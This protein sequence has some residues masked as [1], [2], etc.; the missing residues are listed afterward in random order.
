MRKFLGITTCL[1]ATLCLSGIG[2][3]ADTSPILIGHVNTYSGHG[4]F[5]G[6][7]AG[8]GARLAV[9]EIN[10]AGG[11]LGRKLK[12]IERD[13]QFKPDIGLKEAKDLILN[14]HVHFLTGTLS[15]SVALAVS[16]YA[17]EKKVMFISTLCQSAAITEEQGHRYV[18]RFGSNSTTIAA[19]P[20]M[21]AAKTWGGKKIF[22]LCPD[23]E[24]GHRAQKDFLEFYKK[25]VPD[26]QIV[27]ELWPKTGTTDFTPYISTIMASGADLVLIALVGGEEH[28]FVKQAYPYGFYDKMHVVELLAGSQENWSKV[29]KGQPAP[30]GSMTGCRYP[31][32]AIDDPRSQNFS[33]KFQEITGYVPQFTGITAYCMI[34]ALKESI[35]AAGGTDT[36]KNVDYWTGRVFDTPVGPIKMRACDNQAMW[37]SWSAVTGWSEGFPFPHGT[38]LEKVEDIEAT[39]SKC[40][41]VENARSQKK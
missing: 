28:A 31:Y 20:A 21:R 14:Q 24:W 5:Y 40:E 35:E 11:V 17:K 30:I 16:S 2:L 38:K 13:D 19:V 36:E 10:A 3:C 32:W 39:Y 9:D 4:A 7:G 15:S 8:A 34:Y 12:W 18:F 22:T 6:K 25:E 26:A 27:G 1:L 29:K 37:P 23:Y 33:K 41:A